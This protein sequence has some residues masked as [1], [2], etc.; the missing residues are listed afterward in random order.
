[1]K[2]SSTIKI[3]GVFVLFLVISM[4]FT[5]AAE[6][7]LTYDA[8]GNLVTGDGKYRTYNSLNQLWKIYNGTNSSGV[9]L[10]EYT[11]HPIE[12][13]VAIKKVYNSTGSVVETTYY[14]SKEFVRVI[15]T[16]G[17]F[18]FTYVY[19]DGLLVA[20]DVNGVKTFFINDIKGNIVAVMNS[21]G[22]V[23]ET[24]SYSPF[25]ELLTGGN[26]S[27]YGYEGK[28]YDKTSGQTDY[29][30][31]MLLGPQF[32]Q[33]DSI[34]PSAYDPQSLNR[35]AFERN[36][37]YRYTDPTGH[38]G[39]EVE[40][41]SRVLQPYADGIE[42]LKADM[43]NEWNSIEGHDLIERG[44]S[45]LPYVGVFRLTYSTTAWFVDSNMYQG[46]DGKHLLGPTSEQ[47]SKENKALFFDTVST[48]ADYSVDWSSLSSE[49]RYDYKFFSRTTYILTGNT[50]I[51]YLYNSIMNTAEN[52]INSIASSS[53]SGSSG[54]SSSSL[55]SN[56]CYYGCSTYDAGNTGT[57]KN[58][59]VTEEYCNSHSDM[60]CPNG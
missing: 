35:Y 50:Y 52:L 42:K 28:E 6:M 27:R 3:I 32:I 26:K 54:G 10:E 37:P 13:R 59:G 1:M 40:H 2:I 29:N 49:F 44:V 25:G 5:F 17:T 36:N 57:N 53:S 48:A 43:T 55:S 24:N 9:L 56:F 12:E 47:M 15:N 11:Y 46:D 14:F 39:S 38:V 51:E 21:S 58:T 34:V 7:S 23:T 41:V 20:Q 19:Q 4:P 18:N 31:R 16:S 60:R 30:A 22:N 45:L 33:P 8:N